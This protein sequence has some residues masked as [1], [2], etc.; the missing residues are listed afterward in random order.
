LC[1][2]SSAESKLLVYDYMDNDSLDR[3]L[4]G[5]ALVA[6]GRPMSRA[7]SARARRWTGR[8]GSGTGWLSAPRGGCAMR[9]TWQLAT[10]VTVRRRHSSRPGSSYV[11]AAP[12]GND[13]PAA[14][15]GGGRPATTR[16]AR[17]AARSPTAAQGRSLAR[18]GRPCSD[19]RGYPALVRFDPWLSVGHAHTDKVRP[20]NRF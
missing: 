2:L 9:A 19:I 11:A 16:G 12:Y 7:W 5:D 13:P 3:W 14:R 1:C 4:H 18:E 8:R 6:G 17:P 15:G 10:S 20:L